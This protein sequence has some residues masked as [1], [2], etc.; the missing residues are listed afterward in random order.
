MNGKVHN[1]YETRVFDELERRIENTRL[2]I[3]QDLFND[4]ACIALNQLPPRYVRFDI[5]TT[6]Y[7][8]P[9]EIQSMRSDVED[10]VEFAMN[11]IL[12]QA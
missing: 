6:F 11:K 9:E 3:D 1:Y 12:K 8:T 10:A 7:S 2:D 4:I 5:D